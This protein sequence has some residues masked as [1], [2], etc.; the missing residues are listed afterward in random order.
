[1]AFVRNLSYSIIQG[2]A[3]CSILYLNKADDDDDDDNDVVFVFF[4]H[5]DIIKRCEGRVFVRRAHQHPQI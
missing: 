3:I 2:L 4:N 1:M 5:R